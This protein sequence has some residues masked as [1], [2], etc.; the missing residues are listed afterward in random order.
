[1]HRGLPPI[2]APHVEAPTLPATGPGGTATLDLAVATGRVAVPVHRPWLS[3]RGLL[4]IFAVVLGAVVVAAAIAAYVITRDRDKPICEDPSLPCAGLRPAVLA[5]A[6]PGSGT[7][8]GLTLEAEGPPFPPLTRYSDTVLGFSL[9]YDPEL[10]SVA[11]QDAGFLIL[12]A[13]G[14]AVA[15]IVEGGPTSAFDDQLIFDARRSLMEGALLAFASDTD[16]AHTLLG[17]PILGHRP[18]ISG[19]FGGAIDTPQGPSIDMAVAIIAANDGQITM[20]ATLI[21]PVEIR[22]AGLAVADTVINT[23][24]WPSDPVVR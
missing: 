14:G 12:S 9:E 23:F 10:W 3:Q 16:P 1:M 4:A 5:L 24:T 21:A 19:I 2:R 15:L 6:V 8:P 18:G 7:G 11:Q 22:G 17:T 13:G 20:V